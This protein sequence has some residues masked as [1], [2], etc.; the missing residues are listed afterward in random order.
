MLNNRELLFDVFHG[1]RHGALRVG[2][3]SG[4]GRQPSRFRCISGCQLVGYLSKVVCTRG[5][6]S[7]EVASDHDIWTT[8]GVT[9][10]I[11]LSAPPTRRLGAY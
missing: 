8:E 10:D 11:I 5:P 7:L 2:A 4:L 3:E 9:C 1:L 6:E